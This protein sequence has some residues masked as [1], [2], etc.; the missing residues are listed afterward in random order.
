MSCN[1]ITVN[2]YVKHQILMHVYM[3][4]LLYINLFID[5]PKTK[6]TEMKKVAL[7]FLLILLTGCTKDCNFEQGIKHYNANGGAYVIYDM[8]NNE[9]MKKSIINFNFK[10]AY[11]ADFRE[12]ELNEKITPE[13]LLQKYVS[14]IK[15][16][17][18]LQEVLRQNI[19]SG[20][21]KRANIPGV[22][23]FGFASTSSKYDDINENALSEYTVNMDKM[24]VLNRK[25][26]LTTFLGHIIISNNKHY[27]LLVILDNP[28]PLISTYGWRTAGWNV[29]VLARDI[30]MDLISK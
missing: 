16:N 8:K 21:G 19:I 30:L 25:D 18:E 6:G 1:A 10:Q 2:Q 7:L 14:K 29:V 22:E 17:K 5:Q 23:V 4:Y 11:H 12:L 3:V 28:Q 20:N 13:Q 26:V 24:H 9:M 15:D 27:A